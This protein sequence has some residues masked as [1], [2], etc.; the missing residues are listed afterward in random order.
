MAFLI[1]IIAGGN[2]LGESAKRFEFNAVLGWAGQAGGILKSFG[3]NLIQRFVL[4]EASFSVFQYSYPLSA[5]LTLQV[6]LGPVSPYVTGGYGYS[7]SGFMVSNLAAGL[8]LW[9]TAKT[10]LLVDY[11][12]FRFTY[13]KE[14]KKT[15]MIGVGFAYRF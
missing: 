2:A 4:V 5:N 7:F 12:Q 10:A 13:Q 14:K 15:T 6:P 8:K 9:I 11:R 3:Y 1:L